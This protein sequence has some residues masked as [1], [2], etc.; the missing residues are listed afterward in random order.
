MPMPE[1]PAAESANTSAN[2]CHVGINRAA[3]GAATMHASDTCS[4]VTFWPRSAGR[5]KAKLT[6]IEAKVAMMT[7]LPSDAIGAP[8]LV[9]AWIA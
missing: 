6:A 5:R 8:R 9:M 2:P 3:S 1:L 7:K 4:T